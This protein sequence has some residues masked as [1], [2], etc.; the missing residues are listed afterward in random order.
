MSATLVA[1]EGRSSWSVYRYLSMT[2]N[3]AAEASSMVMGG[4]EHAPFRAVALFCFQDRGFRRFPAARG[5]VGEIWETWGRF[6]A[7]GP[8]L[9]EGH[10]RVA[11]R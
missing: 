8:V 4:K 6:Y 7:M 5:I 3:S 11:Y 2:L 10:G 9:Y 1:Q